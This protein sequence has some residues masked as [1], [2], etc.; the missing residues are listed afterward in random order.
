[1]G[2]RTGWAAAT[3]LLA[4]P[5]AAAAPPVPQSVSASYNVLRNGAR[6]AVMHESFEAADGSYR[7][8]SETHAIGLLALLAPRPLRVTSSGRLSG[9][10]LAPLHFEGKRG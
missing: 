2:Y 7:I 4:L 8:A 3:L 1:M 6:V 5:G 9:D 10:G